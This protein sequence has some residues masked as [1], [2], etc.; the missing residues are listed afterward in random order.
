MRTVPFVDLGK[1]KNPKKDYY[2]SHAS[3]LEPNQVLFPEIRTVPLVD[4]GKAK[5][6]KKDDYCLNDVAKCFK[7]GFSE[8]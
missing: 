6:P 1:A 5:N 3:Q 8:L 2:L 7:S 4:P